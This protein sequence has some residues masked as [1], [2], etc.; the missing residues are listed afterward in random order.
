MV[1]GM[2]QTITAIIIIALAVIAAAIRLF[3]FFRR[4]EKG[5]DCRPESCASC[6]YSSG[7]GSCGIPGEN[8]PKAD[9]KK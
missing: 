9:E 5:S 4:R 2:C 7:S 8:S 6:P 1:N 3:R